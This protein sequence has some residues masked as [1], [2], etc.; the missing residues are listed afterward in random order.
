[1]KSPRRVE[2]RA[3]LLG[4]GSGQFKPV[5][6][7]SSQVLSTWEYFHP[8]YCNSTLSSSFEFML[9]VMSMH[10]NPG[11]FVVFYSVSFC[12]I[13]PILYLFKI[14]LCAKE[15]TTKIQW[16][17]R[18]AQNCLAP[19]YYKSGH[20]V[21]KSQQSITKARWQ[22][23]LSRKTRIRVPLA[24]LQHYLDHLIPSGA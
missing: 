16:L 24:G 17:S 6:A 11:R 15:T 2:S 13:S 4:F 3:Q 21:D 20:R 14:E 8:C 12:F 19:T 10:W 1:M 18:L 5:Q 22:S 23:W 7:S 9:N